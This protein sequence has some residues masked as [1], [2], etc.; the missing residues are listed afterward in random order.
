MTLWNHVVVAKGATVDTSAVHLARPGC[1]QTGATWRGPRRSSRHPPAYSACSAGEWGCVCLEILNRRRNRAGWADIGSEVVLSVWAESIGKT[2]PRKRRKPWWYVDAVETDGVCVCLGMN[3]VCVPCLGMNRVCVALCRVCAVLCAIVGCMH[4]MSGEAGNDDDDDD[5]CTRRKSWFGRHVRP[6]KGLDD[7]N[8]FRI[9]VHFWRA[10]RA[11]AVKS[12]LS[13]LESRDANCAKQK[14][15]PERGETALSVWTYAC[16]WPR[17]LHASKGGEI[18]D[19]KQV[20]TPLRRL[21]VQPK[22]GFWHD[23]ILCSAQLVILATWNLIGI[24][25]V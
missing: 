3:R 13:A 10:K 4:W 6:E 7:E 20:R 5:S 2:R 23:A 14:L 8:Y 17:M 12:A 22:R 21:E 24:I 11:A 18:A 1:L 19:E 16:P 15:S 25:Y 9:C